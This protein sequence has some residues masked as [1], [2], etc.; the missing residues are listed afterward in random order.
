MTG[1]DKFLLFIIALTAVLS[2][3]FIYFNN[4][5]PEQAIISVDGKV[6]SRINLKENSSPKQFVVEGVIGKST[7]ELQNG[8][9][10][11]KAAPCKNQICVHQGWIHSPG[12]SIVC[13]PGKIVIEVTGKSEI[14]A[15]SR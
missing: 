11:M 6:V 1:G 12:Q 5:N 3:F 8:K 7:V 2:A 4:K 10:R 13:L 9:I 14:D 15:V